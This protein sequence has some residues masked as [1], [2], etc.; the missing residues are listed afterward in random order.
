MRN[1]SYITSIL[2]GKPTK[3]YRNDARGI[4]DLTDQ[5]REA[6]VGRSARPTA[7]SG[8]DRNNA[9]IAID[10]D[11]LATLNTLGRDA[12]AKYRGDLVLARDNRAMA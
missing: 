5:V 12:R 1:H 4:S 6:R 3:S 8:T 10:R 7:L 11:P 2:K 9:A